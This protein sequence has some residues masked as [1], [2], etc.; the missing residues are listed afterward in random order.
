MQELEKI[1]NDAMPLKIG[2]GISRK[3]YASQS[4]QL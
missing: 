2:D 3:C 1:I 4:L